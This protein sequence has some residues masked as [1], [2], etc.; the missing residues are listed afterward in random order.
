MGM[1]TRMRRKSETRE[2]INTRTRTITGGGGE[3][4]K[5]EEEDK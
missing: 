5:E 1:R 4:R 3:R 2:I